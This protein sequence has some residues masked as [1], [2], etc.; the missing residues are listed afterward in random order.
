MRDL[1]QDARAIAR[2][3]VAARGSAMGE[4]DKHL[5]T[6]ADNVVAFLAA[7]AGYKA[8]AACIVLML[9]VIKSL[10][11]G[12]AEAKTLCIHGSLFVVQIG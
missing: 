2:L 7:N 5:K 11:F 4:V 3:R 9:R 1:D 12:C 10:G 8:H 6:L